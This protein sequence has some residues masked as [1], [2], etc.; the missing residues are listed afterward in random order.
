MAK[1]TRIQVKTDIGTYGR[2]L[3]YFGTV[4]EVAE[5]LLQQDVYRRSRPQNL[6][7]KASLP[8]LGAIVLSP[9]GERADRAAVRA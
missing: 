1:A 6:T 3:G 9:C 2:T 4:E 7:G 8:F 5:W